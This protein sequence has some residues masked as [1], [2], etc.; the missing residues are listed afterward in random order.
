MME[1][2]YNDKTG[3]FEMKSTLR[4]YSQS[5][6]S[7]QV[8][9][10][11]NCYA[12]WNEIYNEVHKRFRNRCWLLTFPFGI[13]Y[14]IEQVHCI[15][16]SRSSWDPLS[17]L[18]IIVIFLIF[19]TL[20]GGL[21]GFGLAAFVEY[22]TKS[23]WVKKEI[24]KI[25][26]YKHPWLQSYHEQQIEKIRKSNEQSYAILNCMYV[27]WP[28][29]IFVCKVVYDNL[30]VVDNVLVIEI[31]FIAT[32]STLIAYLVSMIAVAFWK[33]VN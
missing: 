8:K 28:I 11:R 32:F 24:T 4:H 16:E 27:V 13:W 10:N 6:K 18:E 9:N 5:R 7:T 1:L 21:I 29:M 23:Y 22:F 33:L 26:E 15:V 25:V 12:K 19:V 30:N 20:W 31:L 2:Q 17:A 14:G 3:N